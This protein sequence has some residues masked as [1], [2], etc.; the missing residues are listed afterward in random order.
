MSAKV[1]GDVSGIAKR[2]EQLSMTNDQQYNP[3]LP[4]RLKNRHSFMEKPRIC[5]SPPTGFNDPPIVSCSTL[6]NPKHRKQP[7]VPAPRPSRSTDML[8]NED[9]LG[10][11]KGRTFVDRF[12]QKNNVIVGKSIMSGSMPD[13]TTVTHCNTADEAMDRNKPRRP[14]PAIP[15]K[16]P[17]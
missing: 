17:V 9:D 10:L 13:L 16:I 5:P 2:F 1:M 12:N 3:I 7:P 8:S 11:E 6:P 15:R 4:N 14:P